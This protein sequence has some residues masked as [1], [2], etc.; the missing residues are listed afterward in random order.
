MKEKST[1]KK[2]E[3]PKINPN[4]PVVLE[5]WV[6]AGGRCEF[7]D[8]NK[9]LLKDK[10]TDIKAKL[11]DI[12][13]IVARSKNGPRGNDPLPLIKRNDISN[14]MLLCPNHHRKIDNKKLVSKYPKNRLIKYKK[15]HEDRIAFLSGLKDEC[16]TVVLRF[17]GIIRGN[18]TAISKE[19]IRQAI[20]HCAGKYPEY[21]NGEDP[22]DINLTAIPE[23]LSKQYWNACKR[24]IDETFKTQVY[25]Q[26]EN[27]NIKHIS[28]F[29]LARIPLLIYLGSRMSDKIPMDVYQKMRNGDEG[30]LWSKNMKS[31]RFNRKLLQRGKV[32]DKVALILSL[33]GKISLGS[34]PKSITADSTIYEIVPYKTSPNRE[35]IKTKDHLDAFKSCLQMTLRDIERD[36][37]DAKK[38]HLFPAVPIS[39]AIICGKE[40]LTDITPPFSIYDIDNRG[41]FKY[42]ME[43]K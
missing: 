13:H 25:P 20:L 3:C 27:N 35:L 16:K 36:H 8:C 7:W 29:A 12:G 4:D 15:E 38:I 39:A 37:K 31:I 6:K 19:Q 32:S 22:I 11:A 42:A 43:V 14:L 41:Q 2:G 9:Y 5:L 10:L 33:S 21:L 23:S 28:L 1:F 18:R 24:K 34:V 26:I 17:F 40:R 30:W